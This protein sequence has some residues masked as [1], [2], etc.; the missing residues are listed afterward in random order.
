MEKDFTINYKGNIVGI[1]CQDGHHFVAHLP[2]RELYLI[3]KE[4][5]EGASHWFE[6]GMDA[7]TD[8]SKE[9]GILIEK[10]IG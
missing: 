7:A 6:K 3:L 2:N 5:T 10:V 1:K 8:T 4:D 9:I